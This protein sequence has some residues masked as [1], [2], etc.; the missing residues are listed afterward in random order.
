MPESP[1]ALPMSATIALAQR[2]AARLNPGMVIYR[3]AIWGAGKTT[4]VRGVPDHWAIP[5]V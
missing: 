4:L 3:M 1:W 2:L 5:G